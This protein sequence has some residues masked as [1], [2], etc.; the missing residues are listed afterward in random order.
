VV[1]AGVDAWPNVEPVDEVDPKALLE[2]G[3][4]VVELPPPNVEALVLPNG[5]GFADVEEPPPNTVELDVDVEPNGDLAGA[6]E[7]V[8]KGDVVVDVL[9]VGAVV[10]DDVVATDAPLDTLGALPKGDDCFMSP[11]NPIPPNPNDDVPDGAG[12]GLLS[13]SGLLVLYLAA[14]FA[15]ISRSFPC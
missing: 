12:A 13:S 3:V 8:P 9:D 15:N 5:L 14:S 10:A 6:I 1:A 4:A 7:E 2:N 11:P